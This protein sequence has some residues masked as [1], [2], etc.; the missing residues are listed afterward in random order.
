MLAVAMT[1]RQLSW[2]VTSLWSN[3]HVPLRQ[4]SLFHWLKFFKNKQW[5]RG[6]EI[7]TT[8]WGHK[9][10]CVMAWPDALFWLLW[11]IRDLLFVLCLFVSLVICTTPFGTAFF[12]CEYSFFICFQRKC[13]GNMLFIIAVVLWCLFLLLL[14]LF[15]YCC[16]ALLLFC[17]VTYYMMV[18]CIFSVLFFCFLFP[19]LQFINVVF[20]KF[21]HLVFQRVCF[22]RFWAWCCVNVCFFVFAP[23][24]VAL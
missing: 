23:T 9:R 17:F 18:L 16:T 5:P 6:W 20:G 3:Q 12:L 24:T 1:L 19:F 10:C 11:G 14:A 4:L 15:R 13:C 8:H 7:S 22:C 21:Y 2:N